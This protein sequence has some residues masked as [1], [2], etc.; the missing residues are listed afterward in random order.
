MCNLLKQRQDLVYSLTLLCSVT[1]LN[2]SR[3]KGSSVVCFAG[4]LG[5]TAAD[6]LSLSR[7]ARLPVCGSDLKDF[8]STVSDA[9]MP[10]V[11]VLYVCV[12]VLTCLGLWWVAQRGFNVRS[13]S[14]FYPD[15]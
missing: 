14:K 7:H 8:L 13:R 4:S 5:V 12:H 1:S 9:D 3:V 10:H 11:A 2:S 15:S 6:G